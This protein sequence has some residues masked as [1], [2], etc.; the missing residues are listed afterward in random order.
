MR[1]R[2]LVPLVCAV[3]A[4]AVAVPV[5]PAVLGLQRTEVTST[6]TLVDGV[7]VTLMRPSQSANPPVVII[8]HGFAGSAVIM[9]SLA[10]QIVRAGAVA[11]TFDFVGHGANPVPMPEGGGMSDAGQVALQNDLQ[12]V[13]DWVDQQPDINHEQ[14][15][16]LGHSM[17]AGAVVRYAVEHPTKVRSVVA[18]SLPSASQ[19]PNRQ[20]AIPPNLLLLVGAAEPASFANAA[21]D[22]LRAG[23]P[24]GEIGIDYGSAAD[25]TLRSAQVIPGAEHVGIVFAPATATAAL[26][27]FSNTLDPAGGAIASVASSNQVNAL[28]WL[29]LLLIAGLLIMVPVAR[30]LFPPI[31][32]SPQWTSSTDQS[33][34]VS[35]GRIW[36]AMVATL[37]AVVVA[38][39]VASLLQSAT[40]ALPLAVGGYLVSWFATAGLVLFALQRTLPS[41]RS[42]DRSVYLTVTGPDLIRALVSTSVAVLAIALPSMAIWAP[43]ALVGDRWWLALV[44]LSGF[45]IFFWAEEAMVHTLSRPRRWIL[46]LIDRVLIVTALLAAIPLLG[47]PGF[48]LL[49]LP[50]MVLLLILLAAFAS[51][52]ARRQGAFL[53]TVLVQA[54]PLALLSA[55]TFPLLMPR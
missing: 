43:F 26:Q 23:Y 51:I 15:G 36:M 14:V 25:G 9:R 29:A 28:V 5:L 35:R 11:V 6:S 41:L 47:A 53:A 22:G 38:D 49:L 34:A 40:A 54:V 4:V 33:S 55:S 44:M 42:A 20:P 19:I 7:P 21:L 18:V 50:L 17:G 16:L 24:T 48:L 39:L 12:T 37:I 45:L 52:L 8:A 32:P 1:T 2:W 3:V 46:V 10:E 31:V 13:L 30:L 27:W